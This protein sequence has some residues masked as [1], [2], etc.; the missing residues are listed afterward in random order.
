MGRSLE[1]EGKVF[2]GVFMMWLG[3]SFL[4]KEMHYIRSSL[5]WPV[6]AAGLGILLILR[7]L[8]VY[9][10]SGYWTNSKKHIFGGGFFLMLSLMRYYNFQNWWPIILVVIGLATI[11]ENR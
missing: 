7:G 11:F 1:D 9:Q 6:F 8:M 10:S 2:G 5:W 4:L 3:V